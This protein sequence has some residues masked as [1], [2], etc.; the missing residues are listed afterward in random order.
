[1]FRL[2]FALTFCGG[3]IGRLGFG[4]RSLRS[5]F[6]CHSHPIDDPLDLEVDGSVKLS[7]RVS[8]PV[9]SPLLG[10]VSPFGPRS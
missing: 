7:G 10:D 6:R 5:P 9:Y 8:D 4:G 3:E 2:D 1:L